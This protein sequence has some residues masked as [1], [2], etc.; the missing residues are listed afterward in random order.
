VRPPDPPP[1]ACYAPV[2]PPSAPSRGAPPPGARP[3]FSWKRGILHALLFLGVVVA[4]GAVAAVV[5]RP[6]EPYR[7]GQGVGRLAA[8]AGLLGLGFSWLLQS[9]R[10]RLAWLVVAAAVALVAG[11]A[12]FLLVAAPAAVRPAPLTPQE[13]AALVPV[14]DGDGQRLLHPAL[15]FSFPHPGP[16]Y[17][18]LGEAELRELRKGMG[19]PALHAWGWFDADQGAVLVVGLLKDVRASR[20]L[21]AFQSGLEGALRGS[22]GAKVEEDRVEA[23]GDS[24]RATLRGVLPDGTFLAARSTVFAS[25]AT[26][27][28]YLVAL[29]AFTPTRG[30]LDA[31]LDGLRLR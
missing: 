19:D 8:F 16:G 25:A 24:G 6:V 4:A 23:S 12:V 11:L 14:A 7:F 31:T 21:E 26:G 1:P 10:R 5:A 18:E 29:V 17:A 30:A 27:H 15:G 9:G 2:A 28:S 20:D 3:A 13:T 22:A